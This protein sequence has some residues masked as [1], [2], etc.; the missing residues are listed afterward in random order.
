MVPRKKKKV[1]PRFLLLVICGFIC[2]HM[3]VRVSACQI[4]Y[5]DCM[6]QG[7]CAQKQFRVQ[8]RWSEK[9]GLCYCCDGRVDVTQ[10]EAQG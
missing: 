10:F 6:Y 2:V 9:E 8:E 1:A 7:M 5:T 4:L 3:H